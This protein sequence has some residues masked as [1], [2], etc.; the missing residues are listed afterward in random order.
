[1][2]PRARSRHSNAWPPPQS[3]EVE[4]HLVRHAATLQRRP[5][6]SLGL[7]IC[8]DEAGRCV[9][10]AVDAGTPAGDCPDLQPRDIICAVYGSEL[11]PGEDLRSRLSHF[12]AEPAVKLGILRWQ[13]TIHYPEGAPQQPHTSPRARALPFADSRNAVAASSEPT[14]APPQTAPPQAAPPQATQAARPGA[15]RPHQPAT[16]EASPSSRH[17]PSLP[18]SPRQQRQRQPPPPPPK[19]PQSK[20]PQSPRH[21]LVQSGKGVAPRAAAQDE[22]FTG[23]ELYQLG[24]RASRTHTDSPHRNYVDTT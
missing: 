14:V 21:V 13:H 18:V 10:S 20:S 24:R 15:A 1:M 23:L 16:A 7:T 11:A 8:I 22:V 9:I 3:P 17:R 19:S 12:A 4:A 6:E 2:S 5:G